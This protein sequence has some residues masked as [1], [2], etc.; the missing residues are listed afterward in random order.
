MLPLECHQVAR[1]RCDE[2][3]ARSVPPLDVRPSEQTRRASVRLA[4]RSLRG[5][6]LGLVIGLRRAALRPLRV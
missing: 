5:T 2:Y 4:V 1:I 3:F 6:V